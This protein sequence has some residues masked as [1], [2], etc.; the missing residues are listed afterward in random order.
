MLTNPTRWAR[1]AALCGCLASA[2]AHATTYYVDY[3]GG[4]DTNDGLSMNTPWKR[5]PGMSGAVGVAA[6]TA[7]MPGDLVYFK[8][9][10]TWPAAALP[11]APAQSG[12]AGNP[13]VFAVHKGWGTGAY[14]ILDGQG[15]APRAIGSGQLDNRTFL[16]FDGFW[17]KNTTSTVVYA[18]D[19]G[20]FV[21]QNGRVENGV[22]T[23]L[24]EAHRKTALLDSIIDGTGI[25]GVEAV[26]MFQG[27]GTYDAGMR[28]A[29]IR[30]NRF[31]VGGGTYGVKL[32]GAPGATVE[33]NYFFGATN[34]GMYVL[35]YRTSDFGTVRYNVIDGRGAQIAFNTWLG[36][37]EPNPLP[38]G[39]K[40]YNN[41]FIGNGQGIAFAVQSPTWDG[42]ELYNNV[43]YDFGLGIDSNGDYTASHNTLFSCTTQYGGSGARTESN[44]LTTDPMLTNPAVLPGGATP[45]TGSALINSGIAFDGYHDGTNR[46]FSGVLVPQESAPERG[47]FE[48]LPGGQDN[49]APAPPTNLGSQ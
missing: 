8:A 11:L 37:P 49:L 33:R 30:G 20:D 21:F 40:V 26:V 6:A 1:V 43:I 24:F 31:N 27:G 3:A 47:A 4:L 38:R 29:V 14:A 22:N 18:R 35:V 2:S 41:T 48:Y 19:Y 13:I 46:S 25:S 45:L 10:V 39:H 34:S 15:T 32:A 44:T 7:L 28:G 16:T 17:C 36:T 12:T 23:I 9:G 42:F 5:S